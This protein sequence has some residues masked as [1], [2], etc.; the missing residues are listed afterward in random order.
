MAS[1]WL[2][3]WQSE[4]LE[5]LACPMHNIEKSPVTE[6]KILVSDIKRK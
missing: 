6:H 3:G 4:N 1:K 5:D 2:H